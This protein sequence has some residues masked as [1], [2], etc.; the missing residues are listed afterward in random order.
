MI[1]SQ[2]TVKGGHKHRLENSMENI[3]TQSLLYM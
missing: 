1:A 2:V 3:P